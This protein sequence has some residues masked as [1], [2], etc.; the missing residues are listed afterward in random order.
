[1]SSV[2][3]ATSARGALA[4]SERELGAWRHLRRFREVL[5]R[6]QDKLAV[7]PSFSDPK[8]RLALGDYL[9]LFLLGLFNPVARTLRGLQ[10]ASHLPR[11][12]AEVCGRPVSLG[13]FSEA[14][15]LIDPALLEAVFAEFAAEVTGGEDLP[16]EAR[17]QR[18]LARDSSL[19][20]ALPRM[21]WALYGG[22][23]A[24]LL[25]NAVRL[26]VS[27]HLLKDAP[28]AATVTAGKAC[29]RATLREDIQE[30]AAYVGDR[31]FSGEYRFFGELSARGCTYVIR[32]VESRMLTTMVEE[33]P[34]STADKAAGVFR[35]GKVRLG[36]E[37]NFSEELRVIWL[38]GSAGQIIMLATNLE[39]AE[40]SAAEVARL[41]KCRW[42]VEYFFRWV[43][44]LLG[45]GHWLAESPRGAAI[46]LYLALIG[47]LLLQ[48]DLGRRPS[49]RVWELL[50]W[51]LCG[52]VDEATLAVLLE[53]RLA[54]E[55]HRRRR[56][57][58]KKKA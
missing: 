4:L 22:G 50:Q 40:L 12:Q 55:A 30:G 29:E 18:W 51:H 20:A 3:S 41:Y 24:G 6:V 2:P 16:A 19:F 7:H 14:Q 56:A 39:A 32:L 23:R 13:S 47:A 36:S 33:L 48:L 38:E 37:K 9:S 31:Y 54:E 43:K 44:H 8:R 58:A 15:Y 52:M 28:A 26:H 5:A 11:V 45:C 35:Q 42:Q 17:T 46:Q 10:Q 25:N 53:K 27:F 57:S 34:V 21:R 1:V 49:K